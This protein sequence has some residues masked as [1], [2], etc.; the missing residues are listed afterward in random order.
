MDLAVP[1]IVERPYLHADSHDIVAGHEN[2]HRACFEIALKP[3][4]GV[5][6]MLA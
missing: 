1:T 4:G 2:L 3:M 5:R 6:P